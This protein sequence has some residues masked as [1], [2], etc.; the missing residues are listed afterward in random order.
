MPEI[1]GGD[2]PRHIGQIVDSV[3][4]TDAFSQLRPG[5]TKG[6]IIREATEE[7]WREHVIAEG[8][9]PSIEHPYRYF[10]EIAWD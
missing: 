6:V 9:N 10:Y 4:F 7:E 3:E 1:Y 8:G 2:S 5:G